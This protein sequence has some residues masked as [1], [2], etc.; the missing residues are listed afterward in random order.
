MAD[1][2]RVKCVSFAGLHPRRANDLTLGREYHV[3]RR[4]PSDNEIVVV[5]DVGDESRVSASAF[6][7]VSASASDPEPGRFE[8]LGAEIGKLTDEKN[9]AYGSSVDT[10][11]AAMRLLYPNGI[12]TEQYADVLLQ[13]RIWD[14]QMRIANRKDAFGENPYRDLA[15]YSLLGAGRGAK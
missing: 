14:K 15:G 7:E 6:A 12:T 9:L 2:K 1:T 3:V 5:D 8:Q 10:S 11:V 4:Y 13:V